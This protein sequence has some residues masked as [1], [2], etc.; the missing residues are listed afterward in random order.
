MTRHVCRLLHAR[1]HK[2]KFKENPHKRNKRKESK[3]KRNNDT[4]T[5]LK[6]AAAPAPSI[7]PTPPDPAMVA[8][9][10]VGGMKRYFTMS[11]RHRM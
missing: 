7:A 2:A 9:G 6:V 5:L 1:C 8:T 3:K 11:G 10:T 4:C